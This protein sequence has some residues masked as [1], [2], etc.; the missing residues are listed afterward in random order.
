MHVLGAWALRSGRRA[1]LVWHLHDYLGTRPM[2][3]RLLRWHHGRRRGHGRHQFGECRRRCD[4]RAGQRHPRRHGPQRRGPRSL[5]DRPAPAR[6]SMRCR[7]C[8][9]RRRTRFASGSWRRWRAGRATRHF[10]KPSRGCRRIFPCAPT[11]WATRSI[12]PRAASIRSTSFVS[13]RVRLGVADRVGFTGFVHTPEATFRALHVVVHASTAP[14]PFG[15]VIAEAMACGR[16][17]HR[18]QRRRR[19]GDRHARRRRARSCARRCRRSGG[20]NRRAGGRSGTARAD[21]ARGARDGRAIVRSRA[22]RGRADSDLPR[23]RRMTDTT[24]S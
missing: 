21:R 3:T 5:L 17:R 7:G 24:G 22:A 20:A 15:L 2:T 12:R 1:G 18:Q 9:R 4:T 13:S 11:S 23:Q 14:E 8:R 10:S 6:I 16:A 19:G